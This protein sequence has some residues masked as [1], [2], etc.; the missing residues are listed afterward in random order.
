[1]NRRYHYVG[2]AEIRDQTRA[3]SPGHVISDQNDLADWL[4]KQAAEDRAEPFTFVVD[5]RGNLRLAPQRSEHVACA[6]GAPVLSAGEISFAWDGTRWLVSEIS[7]QSTG[8][9]PDVQPWTAVKAALLRAGIDHP[10]AFT[11][12]IVFRRCP[13]CRQ[14]NIVKDDDFACGVCQAPLPRI[15]NVDQP[16]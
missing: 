3:G 16:D 8:Y 13:R 11:R 4:Q 5:V 2:P 10:D 12:P 9:C 14:R 15:W 7:N 6:G 1:M